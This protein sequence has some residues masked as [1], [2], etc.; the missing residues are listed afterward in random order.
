M[1]P[2]PIKLLNI[3]SPITH[4]QNELLLV[5]IPQNPGSV[6]ARTCFACT[7]FAGSV[8]TAAL[9]ATVAWGKFDFSLE[10]YISRGTDRTL[11]STRSTNSEGINY[12]L[13]RNWRSAY[14]ETG[15][16]KTAPERTAGQSSVKHRLRCKMI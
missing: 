1:H 8:G 13:A 14:E 4:L 5:H 9:A 15:T 11:G 7:G 16:H 12:K 6:V 3:Q 2:Y 10:R